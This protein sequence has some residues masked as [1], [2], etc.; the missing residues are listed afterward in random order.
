MW[1]TLT[2]VSRILLNR[3]YHSS[4]TLTRIHRVHRVQLLVFHPAERGN[5][6][7]VYN[8]GLSGLPIWRGA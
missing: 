2:D 4:V 1:M 5:S 6:G 7:T 8:V 3:F